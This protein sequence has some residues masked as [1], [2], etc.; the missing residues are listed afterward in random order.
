LSERERE[1]ERMFEGREREIKKLRE[2][3]NWRR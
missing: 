3:G 1:R 2:E